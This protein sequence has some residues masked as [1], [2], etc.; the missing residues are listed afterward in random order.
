[1][2]IILH[3]HAAGLLRVV[4][5]VGLDILV[6]VVADDLDG[7]LVRA[8]GA[9]AAEA[10]ELALD[11]AFG[12]G[13]GGGDL[14]EGHVGHVVDDA[15]GELALGRVLLQLVI[16]GEDGGG[17]R[18]LRAEAVA[19]ADNGDVGLAR[20]GKGSAFQCLCEG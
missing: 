11:G 10:P 7:V 5:E 18:V 16:H 1:M 14:L 17:R 3:R 4:L 15:D 8:D 20:V 6:R 9:V 13:G 12:R 19:A 2:I